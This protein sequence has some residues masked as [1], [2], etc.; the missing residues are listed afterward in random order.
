M[1]MATIQPPRHPTRTTG[2]A[3]SRPWMAHSA[4]KDRHAQLVEQSQKFVAQ[5][6]FG[7]VLRQMRQSSFRSNL[8]SG[9]KGAKAFE[10]MLDQQ[11]A[12]RMSRNRAG[13]RIVNSMVKRIEHPRGASSAP[14]LS[15]EEIRQ[16]QG[17][18]ENGGSPV[19][20]NTVLPGARPSP[21]TTDLRG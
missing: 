11:L 6:F 15:V 13:T 10:S 20:P 1:P 12:D 14:S 3:L 2:A 5:S 16:L 18:G 9:G 21:G 7:P 19:R 17:Y 4:G 8:M